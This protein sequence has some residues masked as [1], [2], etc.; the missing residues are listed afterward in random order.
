M[1]REQRRIVQENKRAGKNTKHQDNGLEFE[2][3]RNGFHIYSDKVRK[4]KI[5]L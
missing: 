4:M 3:K 1:D 2:T 5:L